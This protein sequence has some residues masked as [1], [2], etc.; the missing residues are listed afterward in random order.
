MNMLHGNNSR[1]I[2]D[3]V[4]HHQ[5]GRL[6]AAEQIYRQI[7]AV[8]PNHA[9]A[10]ARAALVPSL[11]LGLV[12]NDSFRAACS[13]AVTYSRRLQ[14]PLGLDARTLHIGP[15]LCRWTPMRRGCNRLEQSPMARH[16]LVKRISTPM[17]QHFRLI[18]HFEDRR[19]FGGSSTRDRTLNPRNAPTGSETCLAIEGRQVQV[20]IGPE[21]GEVQV[22]I[23]DPSL[24]VERD[25]DVADIPDDVQDLG[26]GRD[27][28]HFDKHPQEQQIVWAT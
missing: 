25:H 12:W 26:V 6:Q 19:K 20:G 5:A 8:E 23:S 7:L 13:L 4:Q 3:C 18:F 11:A 21:S 17:V 22:K 28:S 10:L 16:L 1:S 14:G 2:G 27:S 24:L 15:R 9:D